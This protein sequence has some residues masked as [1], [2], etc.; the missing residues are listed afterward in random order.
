MPFNRLIVLSFFQFVILLTESKG[1]G[2]YFLLSLIVPMQGNAVPDESERRG[3]ASM[4]E[5]FDTLVRRL[6]YDNRLT[7]LTQQAILENRISNHVM[8]QALTTIGIRGIVT[9]EDGFKPSRLKP[10]IYLAS[11][12]NT[13]TLQ[14][15][16]KHVWSQ[17]AVPFLLVLTP[18]TVEIC[19]G[20]QP[21]S[22]PPISVDYDPL[23]GPLPDTL[24]N[25]SSDRISSS[26]TWSDFEIH[27]DSSI[28]N[29]LVSAI[30]ALN[31]RARREFPDFKN[32][33]NLINALIGKFIYIYVLVDRCILSKKWLRS[34]L[35]DNRQH[36]LSFL[37]AIF[38]ASKQQ[39]EN[40]TA[41]AAMSVFDVVDNAI[42]GSVFTISAEQRR[43][44]PD[45]LCHLI[46]RVVRR[47]EV[48]LEDG[49]Q[50]DFFN[51]SFN[52][53]RTELDFA[54]FKHPIQRLTA[55]MGSLSMMRRASL[56]GTTVHL[57]GP[58]GRQH[59]RHRDQ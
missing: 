49:D 20:F 9:L 30:E 39:P 23:E 54:L 40:W 59:S 32:E 58:V 27:R 22:A 4:T 53:L 38:D 52:V 55:K 41:S 45:G 13:V 8:R 26:V 34:Q 57:K 46:H 19:N 1:Y 11:A 5:R 14:V 7:F 51:V 12:E 6:G 10:V 15:L 35:P 16:R 36:G 25:F 29:K 37:Q 44:I 43:R 21:P 31:N 3:L 42:N 47:G 18:N 24:A 2:L 56:S 28:D 17:G 33:R 50:L 48:L